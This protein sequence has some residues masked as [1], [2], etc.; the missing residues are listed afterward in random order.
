MFHKISKSFQKEEYIT[1]DESLGISYT[2]IYKYN[3]LLYSPLIPKMFSAS[4]QV[5]LRPPAAVQFL[6]VLCKF[7][8]VFTIAGLTNFVL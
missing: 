6:K 3:Y 1:N 2:N 7:P 8:H 4:S 5:I